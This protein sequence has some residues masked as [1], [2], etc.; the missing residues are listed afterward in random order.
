MVSERSERALRKTSI[1]PSTKL[2]FPHSICLARF[3]KN[4]PGLARR[5]FVE[6]FYDI[7]PMFRG[8][9]YYSVT[10]ALTSVERNVAVGPLVASLICSCGGGGVGGGGRCCGVRL[11]SDAKGTHERAGK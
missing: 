9:F 5:S 7:T 2:T 11:E 1:R 3:I 8:T 6:K 4:A 10:N